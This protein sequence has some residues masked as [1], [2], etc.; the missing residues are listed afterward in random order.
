MTPFFDIFYRT[1]TERSGFIGFS[2]TRERGGAGGGR[3]SPGAQQIHPHTCQVY[4]G[5]SFSQKIE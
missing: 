2:A 3:E 5:G 1:N 4:R